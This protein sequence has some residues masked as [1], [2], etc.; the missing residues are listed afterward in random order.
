MATPW[1]N[2]WATDDALQGHNIK[3]TFFRAHL[4]K[5]AITDRPLTQEKKHGDRPFGPSRFE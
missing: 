5:V 3:R 1:V 4:I 2:D